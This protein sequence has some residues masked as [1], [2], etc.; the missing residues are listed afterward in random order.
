MT[1][2]NYSEKRIR[3]FNFP[4]V[5]S[6]DKYD[7]IFDY[8]NQKI[9][10]YRNGIKVCENYSDVN[11]Q[12]IID[13]FAGNNLFHMLN[14]ISCSDDSCIQH[15]IIY[16][17]IVNEKDIFNSYYCGLTDNHQIY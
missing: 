15:F 16:N 2:R 14:T 8:D 11:V 3:I 9:I 12:E 7:V 4:I 5:R 1:E 13:R 17:G 6:F 10:A